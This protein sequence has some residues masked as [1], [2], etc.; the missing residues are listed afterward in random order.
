[1]TTS[2]QV[3]REGAEP[4]PERSVGAEERDDEVDQPQLGVGVEEQRHDVH[5]DQ[6]DA[7]Q[8]G[9]AVHLVEPEAAEAA[10]RAAGAGDD[11]RAPG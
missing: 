6:A 8:G 9:G 4:E 1:M 7:G 11:A 2:E 3:D 5:G 10:D